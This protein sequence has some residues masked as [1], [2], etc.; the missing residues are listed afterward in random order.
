MLAMTTRQLVRRKPT[1]RYT[2]IKLMQSYERHGSIANI[3]I[4][5]TEPKRENMKYARLKLFHLD[6]KIRYNF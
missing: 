4:A 2:T 5:L 6:F 1:T 3:A